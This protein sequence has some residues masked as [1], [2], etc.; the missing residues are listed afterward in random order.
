MTELVARTPEEFVSIAG[1]E[2]AGAL[3]NGEADH[4]N[5]TAGLDLS[6]LGMARYLRKRAASLANPTEA[7]GTTTS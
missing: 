2:L 1:A 4:Y 5:Q 6:F 3:P 7:S